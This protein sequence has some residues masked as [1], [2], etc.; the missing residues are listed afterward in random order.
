M[1]SSK[2]KITKRLIGALKPSPGADVSVMDSELTGYG[3]RIK[4]SG[5]ASYF[6]RYRTPHGAERRLAFAKFGTLTPEEAR[7]KARRLL[8]EVED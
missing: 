1:A 2:A 5:V 8:A 7:A 4:P 3:V 6:V